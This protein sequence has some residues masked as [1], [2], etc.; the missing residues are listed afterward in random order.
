LNAERSDT[1]LLKK[2]V[3]KNNRKLHKRKTGKGGI[4][5]ANK[6]EKEMFG[7]RLFDKVKYKGQSCFIF[8]R[9]TSGYFDV[10][11]LDGMTISAS[12]SYRKLKLLQR[13]ST[14]LVEI[15]K[16]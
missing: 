7:F 3:R 15:R 9:R 5:K 1:Y 16:K 4:R 6:V 2:R 8:G 14:T 12:V 13:S 10:R 11:L